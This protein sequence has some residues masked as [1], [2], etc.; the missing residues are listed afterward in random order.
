MKGSAS[1][2]GARA[3]GDVQKDEGDEEKGDSAHSH[4]A[5][6]SNG[7]RALRFDAG[8]G[9]NGNDDDCESK[10]DEPIHELTRSKM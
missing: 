6:V 10:P 5:G 8:D 9:G 4:H 7:S 2:A 3:I 1:T